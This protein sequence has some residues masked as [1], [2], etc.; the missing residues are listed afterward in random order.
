MRTHG[1][2]LAIRILE[3]TMR[4]LIDSL[5]MCYGIQLADSRGDIGV[6]YA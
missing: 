1:I 3:V 4:Y 2:C 5:D 6:I